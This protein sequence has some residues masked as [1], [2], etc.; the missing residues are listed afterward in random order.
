MQVW[1]FP[2]SSLREFNIEMPDGALLLHVGQQGGEGQLWA[3]V[4]PFAKRVLRR[5]WVRGTG[6]DVDPATYIGT[7]ME[8][9]GAYVWHL[10]E[11]K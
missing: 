4:D 8:N 9:G 2:L 11:P 7:W 10:F 5:F 1:K 3:C 6:H